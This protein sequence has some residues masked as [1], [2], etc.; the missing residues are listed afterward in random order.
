MKSVAVIGSTG[1]V[2]RQALDVIE[3]GGFRV[4]A[5]A[6]GENAELLAEQARRFRPDI[7]AIKNETKAENLSEALAGTGISVLA[8]DEGVSAAAAYARSDIVLNSVVGIAG[9]RPTLAALAAGKT[10]AL[11][12]KESLVCAGELVMATARKNGCRILPVDS[13][14]S[15]V[16]QCLKSGEQGEIERLILTASGGPFF[17]KSREELRGVTVKDALA[18]PTWSMGAKISIDS[19]TMMN[20][21]FEIME[22]GY[23]FSLTEERISVLVHRE[24]IVHSMVEYRDGSVI[25]HMSQPDMR[26]PVQ[27][28]LE[29]PQ[30]G[31]RTIEKLDLVKAGSL[32]FTEPDEATFPAMRL[33]REAYRRGGNA[34]AVLNGANEAAVQLFIEGRIAF[35]EIYELVRSA[36]EKVPHAPV[37]DIEDIFAADKAARKHVFDKAVRK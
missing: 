29:Y 25:A 12:N 27:Y 15:A 17:G 9:L 6:A 3:R 4:S 7:A 30:R 22:A 19:A 2:G 11:A 23:L 20:K 34:G 31:A 26:L 13:E 24:S 18:H 14:H 8:G 36:A 28:A 37:K 5:L 1:S 16:F 33:C 10:L 32:T 21:G 35:T